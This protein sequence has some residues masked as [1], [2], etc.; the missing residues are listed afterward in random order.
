[1]QH[2]LRAARRKAEDRRP[3]EAGVGGT[4]AAKFRRTVERAVNVDQAGDAVV[5]VGSV[6]LFVGHKCGNVG[7]CRQSRDTMVD[8]SEALRDFDREKS[9]GRIASRSSTFTGK[10]ANMT[11]PWGWGRS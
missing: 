8:A 6:V 9:E 1:M 11:T 3:P 10:E 4:H 2:F 5:P 7:G